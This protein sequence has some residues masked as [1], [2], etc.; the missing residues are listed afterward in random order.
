MVEH[1][2]LSSADSARRPPVIPLPVALLFSDELIFELYDGGQALAQIFDP[3]GQARSSEGK[4]GRDS[5]SV[6]PC[7]SH[8]ARPAPAHGSRRTRRR[9]IERI[10]QQDR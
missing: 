1:N 6:S 10:L 3:L 2:P 8:A 5:L 7:L 9:P 4:R